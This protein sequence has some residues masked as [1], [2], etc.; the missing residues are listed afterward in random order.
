MRK[1]QSSLILSAAAILFCACGQKST[2]DGDVVVDEG[3]G[4]ESS[5]SGSEAGTEESDDGMTTTMMEEETDDDGFV[6]MDDMFAP[7]SCDPFLQDCP[8]GEKCVAYASSGGTWDANKCV[9]VTGEGTEGDQCIYD[10]ADLGTD[11]CDEDTVCWNALDQDGMLVGTCY[12][13][14]T[15]DAQN[16]MCENPDSTCRIVNDGAINV[17]LPDCDPLLQECAEGLGCY[18]SGGSQTFQCIIVAGD[19]IPTGEPCGFNN[20]CAPG[21]YCAA[22]EVL[23]MCNGSAC[24]ASFCDL[25]EDPSPCTL[26]YEC[27]PFFEEGMAPPMYESLGLCILP[28]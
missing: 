1:F 23:E 8:D 27:V 6:P 22:A 16:P 25:N 19:G 12:P 9:P 7:N 26:P 3:N 14:C 20:D 18:W 21:H 4:D 28:A 11:D 10:G 17:C 13:F 15:G 5:T 2:D 24:C